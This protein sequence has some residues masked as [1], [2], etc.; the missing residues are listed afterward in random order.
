MITPAVSVLSAV[1][2]LKTV[3]PG[4]TPFVIPIAVAILTAGILSLNVFAGPTA[5]QTVSYC[6][7][8]LH[9]VTGRGYGVIEP[10]G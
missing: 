1:E 3:N 9:R 10:S 4:F 7:D 6:Y 8:E 5:T 2:G